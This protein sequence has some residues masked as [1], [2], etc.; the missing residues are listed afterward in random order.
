MVEVNGQ[1]Y[2]HAVVKPIAVATGGTFAMKT[3]KKVS[4][5]VRAN[6]NP[7]RDAQGQIDGFTITQMETEGSLSMKRSEYEEFRAWLLEQDPGLGVL[8]IVFDLPVSYGGR[9]NALK[10]A[11][12]RGCMLQED[13]FD[14]EDNQDP[15]MVDIP[16]FFLRV[17]RDGTSDTIV[18]EQ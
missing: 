17:D 7:T 15:L 4:W 6:K 18:Y 3:H 12:L 5:R 14:S 1:A 10:T 16:L 2:Q 11:T 13:P 9:V 8:Q